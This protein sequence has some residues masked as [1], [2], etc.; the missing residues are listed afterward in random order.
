MHVELDQ[1]F[2]ARLHCVAVA[3]P[4]EVPQSVG[5][6]DSIQLALAVLSGLRSLQRHAADI[7]R[8]DLD[9]PRQRHQWLDPRRIRRQGNTQVIRR[10]CVADLHP[11]GV[12]FLTG[13]TSV[14]PG[15]QVPLPAG[16]LAPQKLFED[17]GLEQVKL[18]FVLEEAGLMRRDAFQH[19]R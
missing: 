2:Q 7:R 14:A 8:Y 1:F 9:A 11:Q 18:R 4:V 12:S 5:I 15:P 19:R 16:V 10:Q 17:L 3:Q 6:L 13:G